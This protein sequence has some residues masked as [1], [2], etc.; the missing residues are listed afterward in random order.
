MSIPLARALEAVDLITGRG[1][2]TT[3][4]ALMESPYVVDPDYMSDGLIAT[5]SGSEL[6][7]AGYARQTI[8][9]TAPVTNGDGYAESSNDSILTFGPFTDPQG[10]GIEGV[11]G[12]AV[13]TAASGTAGTVRWATLIDPAMLDATQNDTFTLAIGAV[14]VTSR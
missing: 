12:L 8:S 9:W 2:Y 14:K 1:S 6:S 4:L 7:S 11:H 5:I 3:Y 10:S 13:V